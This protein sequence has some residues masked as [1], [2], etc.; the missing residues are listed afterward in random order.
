MSARWD[1]LS[2]QQPSDTSDQVDTHDPTDTGD[3]INSGPVG[4][5]EQIGTAE[6]SLDN[7]CSRAPPAFARHLT[8]VYANHQLS[9]ADLLEDSCISLTPNELS[10]ND[11]SDVGVEEEEEEEEGGEGVA[12]KD[13]AKPDASTQVE[14]E[15]LQGSQPILS[16]LDMT[17][18][19]PMAGDISKALRNLE[20][21]DPDLELAMVSPLMNPQLQEMVT[22]SQEMGGMM[23]PSQDLMNPSQEVMTPS[24]PP[25]V[26]GSSAHPDTQPS[27]E[28]ARN[29]T[30]EEANHFFDDSLGDE[31][32]GSQFTLPC[33]QPSPQTVA[34]DDRAA[35]SHISLWDVE[36][37]WDMLLS[38]ET[39]KVKSQELDRD[40]IIQ[41]EYDISEADMAQFNHS[42]ESF[43]SILSGMSGMSLDMKAS[44]SGGEARRQEST[45]KGGVAQDSQEPSASGEREQPSLPEVTACHQDRRKLLRLVLGEESGEESVDS[46]EEEE[47]VWDDEEEEGGVCFSPITV[48]R[49]GQRQ[50]RQGRAVRDRGIPQLD[51]TAPSIGPIARPT[52]S[53]AG[54]SSVTTS[55]N[56]SAATPGN[57]SVVTSVTSSVETSV[58]SSA[59]TSIASSVV[60]SVASSV[61]TLTTD[62]PRVMKRKRKGRA[63]GV[64]RR[65]KRKTDSVEVK[66]KSC[67]P[68]FDGGDVVVF[69]AQDISEPV[70]KEATLDASKLAAQKLRGVGTTPTHQNVSEPVLRD[71]ETTPTDVPQPKKH[72]LSLRKKPSSLEKWRPAVKTRADR[73]PPEVILSLQRKVC[74][75]DVVRLDPA[76]LKKYTPGLSTT[77]NQCCPLLPASC[78]PWLPGTL[79]ESSPRFPGTLSEC[80]PQLPTTLS[81]STPLLYPAVPSTYTKKLQRKKG[82]SRKP[83]IGASPPNVPPTRKRGRPCK[84]PSTDPLQLSQR[85]RWRLPKSPLNS[86]Q[87][88]SVPDPQPS[89]KRGRHRKTP[90]TGQAELSNSQAGT[91]P[92]PSNGQ[93]GTPQPSN[94]QA[95]TPQPSNSQ[96]GTPQPSNSKAGTPQPSNSQAGTPQPSNSQAGTP[97]P[98]NSQAGTPKP[99]NSQAGT[100]KPSNSQAGTTKPSNSQAGTPKPSS[101]QA[102][103]SKPSNSQAGTPKPSSSQARTPQPSHGLVVVSSQP[104]RKKGRPCKHSVVSSQPILARQSLAANPET[105]KLQK[106]QRKRKRR[107]LTSINSSEVL[108]VMRRRTRR[109]RSCSPLHLSYRTLMMS[110]QN[111]EM[112]LKMALHISAA[113]AA[114]WGVAL[115]AKLASSFAPALNN[116]ASVDQGETLS[117]E[118][119]K[120]VSMEECTSKTNRDLPPGKTTSRLD[121]FHD[122][123]A[124]EAASDRFPN[125]LTLAMDTVGYSDDDST[126]QLSPVTQPALPPSRRGVACDRPHPCSVRV[127]LNAS[128]TSI[129]ETPPPTPPLRT[130]TPPLLDS[131][132]SHDVTPPIQTKTHPLIVS[133]PLSV[134]DS[135]TPSL[136]AVLPVQPETP[137]LIVSLPLF[138]TLPSNSPSKR[139]HVPPS[140]LAG[141]PERHR[142]DEGERGDCDDVLPPTDVRCVVSPSA[143]T[144]SPKGHRG[145]KGHHAGDV[146]P[147]WSPKGYHGGV[148]S[149]SRMT[150]VPEWH[151]GDALWLTD[152]SLEGYH[153]VVSPSALTSHIAHHD[154]GIVSPTR[155]ATHM[156]FITSNRHGDAPRQCC[157]NTASHKESPRPATSHTESPRPATSHTESP[158]PA[159]SHTESPRPATSHTETPRPATSHTETPRPA[160][161]H[162]ESPRKHDGATNLMV[163]VGSVMD[164][165]LRERDCV[166]ADGWATVE[167]DMAVEEDV[168]VELENSLRLHWSSESEAESEVDER[169]DERETSPL[170]KSLTKTGR[171]TITFQQ[172][173]SATPTL[174]PTPKSATPTVEPM[175]KSATPNLDPTPKSATPTPEHISATPFESCVKAK[176]DSTFPQDR[177]GAILVPLIPPLAPKQAVESASKYGILSVTHVKPFYSN[178]A[179]VQI[180]RLVGGGREG[181]RAER[182]EGR[183]GEGRR[184][185]V[186]RVN[187]K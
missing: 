18:L 13:L 7:P 139:S 15:A 186:G 101:S 87:P 67:T 82:K 176:R 119:G 77:L 26:G 172:Y 132:P 185:R 12:S 93:A 117:L 50:T 30:L 8:P 55:G 75:V 62:T 110:N 72:Q 187:N 86:S 142:G 44:E 28:I 66:S 52:K 38:Y 36:H 19:T 76:T 65:K 46:C 73:F 133:I 14:R 151:C 70:A 160:T 124:V 85:K 6:P 159:T 80:S 61:A 112:R 9:E 53:S 25:G 174:D 27:Q 107:S 161:S 43:A 177:K 40:D 100:P 94:S 149:P 120:T 103:T 21:V 16:Q 138:P 48:L 11:S 56:T 47:L 111:D 169:E 167:E 114:V 115:P 60:T 51:G 34:V 170:D 162:T 35:G 29:V 165:P 1:P 131:T 125:A 158:R 23:A 137:P 92:S 54:S 128:I 74:R 148:V 182:N 20:E 144:G 130:A 78:S 71:E 89:K 45:G 145:D 155:L 166:P 49:G 152:G 140:T 178:P 104:M 37:E 123:N 31:I 116:T 88:S 32:T 57:S 95:G 83:P 122:T 69:T 91:P 17:S 41:L 5:N 129:D 98:S 79:R 96:A 58:A 156:E 109:Q 118:Q 68:T 179:D 171:V 135:V 127:D 10:N 63:L 134:L 180:A 42:G 108:A 143:L 121:G 2:A 168:A 64:T 183:Q 163:R 164:S 106:G 136:D 150:G 153:G 173:Q 90:L 175:L 113:E 97:Q 59:V 81:Q 146:T 126:P 24:G 99:S 105:S 84:P 157:G 3:Q 102:G 4:T 22:P 184:K 141:L 181:G 33:A 147:T 39:P 154:G